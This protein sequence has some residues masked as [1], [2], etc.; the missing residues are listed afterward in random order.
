[1][2]EP[3]L[4]ATGLMGQVTQVYKSHS[5]VLLI[6]DLNHALPVQVVPQRSALHC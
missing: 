5:Q 2:L 1:M 4:D 3:V 6:T